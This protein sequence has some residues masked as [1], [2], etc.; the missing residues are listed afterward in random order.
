MVEISGVLNIALATHTMAL[1]GAISVLVAMIF[2]QMNPGRMNLIAMSPVLVIQMCHVVV[3]ETPLMFTKLVVL[4]GQF[5][6][7]N[8]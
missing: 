6:L 5:Q 8:P 2:Q 1:Y 4:L 7:Q 3:Q